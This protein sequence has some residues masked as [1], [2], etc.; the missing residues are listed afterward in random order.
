MLKLEYKCIPTKNILLYFI[1]S[2]LKI[3][4]CNE[5]VGEKIF[6]IFC[7]YFLYFCILSVFLKDFGLL[8]CSMSSNAC[9][10]ADTIS[11]SIETFGIFLQTWQFSQPCRKICPICT[12]FY[13]VLVCCCCFVFAFQSNVH[14]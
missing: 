6:S 4:L 2:V 7:L 13:Y 1:D 9:I 8:S 3:I 12:L 5:G 10:S 11:F 14:S